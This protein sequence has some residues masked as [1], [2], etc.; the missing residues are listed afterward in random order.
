MQ[1]KTVIAVIIG[2]LMLMV[3]G[4][5]MWMLNLPSNPAMSPETATPPAAQQQ[6]AGDTVAGISQE[7]DAVTEVNL[8]SELAPVD[9]DINA[10]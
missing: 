8:E 4:L 5:G 6:P 9:Q 2:L 3:I 10:L 1:N 7:L